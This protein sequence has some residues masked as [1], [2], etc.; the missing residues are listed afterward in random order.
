MKIDR[1][2]GLFV[3]FEGIT[4][5]H[6]FPIGW[7]NPTNFEFSPDDYLIDIFAS[8]LNRKTP[9]R[10]L[11]LKV[12]LNED[13]SKI[14]KARGSVLFD[15]NPDTRGYVVSVREALGSPSSVPY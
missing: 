4:A 9:V 13:E 5:Y 14:L 1:G 7:S 3:P 11:Q 2:G 15:W 12:R 6:H 10:L 8:I